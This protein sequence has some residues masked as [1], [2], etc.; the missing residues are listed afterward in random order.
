MA[1]YSNDLVFSVSWFTV[2]VVS[3]KLSANLCICSEFVAYNVYL[4]MQ[5]VVKHLPKLVMR[6][7]YKPAVVNKREA[8]KG[9]LQF[10]TKNESSM[11]LRN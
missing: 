5:L 10:T 9:S 11:V 6:S 1:C 8:F 4:E 3:H 2:N 7:A